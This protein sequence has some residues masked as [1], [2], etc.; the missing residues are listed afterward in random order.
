MVHL[1]RFATFVFVAGGF[2]TASTFIPAYAQTPNSTAET[3]ATTTS[4]ISRNVFNA[5]SVVRPVT[6]V[7]GDFVA[8]GGKIIVDQYVKGDAALA[9]GSVNVRAPIGDDLRVAAADVILESA[10]GGELFAAA[11]SIALTKTARI[12]TA[13]SLFAGDVTIDGNI[14]GP[15]KVHAK[16]IVLN[17]EVNGDARLVAE[18]IE[19]GP[20]ARIS[21]ILSYGTSSHLKLADGAIVGGAITREERNA[22][23]RGEDFELGWNRHREMSGPSRTVSAFTFLALLSCATV[24]LLIFPT[25]STRVSAR[26][27]TSPWLVLM[28]GIGSLLSLPV[29]AVLLFITI[30]GIPLGIMLLG[31]YPV[32]LLTGYVMGVFFV[33]RRAQMAMRK[34]QYSSFATTIGF[35]S[36]ALVLVMLFGY[37]PFVGTLLILLLTIAGAGACMLELFNRSPSPP[38]APPIQTVR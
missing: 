2:F 16:K 14:D 11:G 28:A 21:G 36:L 5:G 6:T 23:A 13:V 10:I 24:F 19:L 30:F 9:A 32:L 18:Q 7:E 33:S 4:F 12:A 29:L 22:S 31:L 20:T 8:V 34:D 15:L 17:G 3:H 25:F 26:I 35:F 38:T 27:S 37:L 1:Y